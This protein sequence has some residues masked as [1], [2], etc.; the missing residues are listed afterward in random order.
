MI[1]RSLGPAF[2][3]AIGVIFTL[4]NVINISLNLQGFADIVV[5]L[6]NVRINEPE[7]EMLLVEPVFL[8]F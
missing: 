6:M 3:A 5:L 8:N 2:G 7:E 1:A 4:A